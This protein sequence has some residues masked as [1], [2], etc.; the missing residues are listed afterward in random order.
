MHWKIW[1]LKS[2][3]PNSATSWTHNTVCNLTLHLYSLSKSKMFFFFLPQLAAKC[4]WWYQKWKNPLPVWQNKETA[5]EWDCPAPCSGQEPAA[6]LGLQSDWQSCARLLRLLCVLL[7]TWRLLETG[8]MTKKCLKNVISENLGT[9]QENC[10][11]TFMQKHSGL[12]LLWWAWG[13]LWD[14]TSGGSAGT[15]SK[16]SASFR[17]NSLGLTHSDVSPTYANLWAWA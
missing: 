6:L 13:H 16:C 5:V 2:P 15:Q 12:G 1:P 10:C 7:P 11:Q 17:S 3:N 9:T 8:E 4:L 14:R